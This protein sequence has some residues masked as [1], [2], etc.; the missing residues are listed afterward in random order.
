[1]DFDIETEGLQDLERVF[2]EVGPRVGRNLARSTTQAVATQIAKEIRGRVPE[3]EGD[4]RR[5]I[6]ARRRRMRFGVAVSEIYA[7][8]YWWFIE[9]GTVKQSAQPF[10][11]PVADTFDGP[12]LLSIY[13]EE[14]GNKLEAALRRAWK[15]NRDR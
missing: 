11:K 14:F 4:L 2:R 15:R 5:S 9:R 13:L 6:K 10:V 12:K 3:D 7:H 1:M 8:F